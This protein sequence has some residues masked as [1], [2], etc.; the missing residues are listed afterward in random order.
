MDRFM[1][2]YNHDRPHMSLDWDSQETPAQAF[3]RKMPKEGET[4]IDGKTGEE[5]DVR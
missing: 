2:R 5:F 4:A 1:G 3:M